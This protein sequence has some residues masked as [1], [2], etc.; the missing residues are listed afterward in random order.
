V[1]RASDLSP[2]VRAKL[3]ITQAPKK[4]PKQ[5]D[6]ADREFLFQC[7]ALKL[8]PVFAQWRFQNSRHP[9][10][11]SRK[12]RCDFV[13]DDPYRVMVEIDGGIWIKGAHGHPT[14]IIRNMTKGNDAVLLGYAV[15]HF[16]PE[17]VTSGHAVAFTQKVLKAKGWKP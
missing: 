15:L 10:S 3:G 1:I 16:T 5:T 2:A 13:F 11:A 6:Q 4:R 12:W 17:E 7:Q 8:P 9:N 14:D